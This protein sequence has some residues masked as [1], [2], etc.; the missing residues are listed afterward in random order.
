MLRFPRISLL[1][2]SDS[3]N[4]NF[5]SCVEHPVVFVSTPYSQAEGP[6]VV[7]VDICI[8]FDSCGT[9]INLVAF[10]YLHYLVVKHFKTSYRPVFLK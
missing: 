3:L 1:F 5:I 8:T 6:M 9:S 4:G 10:I 2:I 7:T